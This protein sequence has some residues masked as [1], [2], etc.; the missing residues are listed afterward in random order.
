MKVF[1][2]LLLAV[3]LCTDPGKI[4]LHLLQQIINWKKRHV[5]GFDTEG[6]NTGPVVIRCLLFD[7]VSHVLQGKTQFLPGTGVILVWIDQLLGKI[8]LKKFGI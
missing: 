1:F 3:V 7:G 2:V 5:M 4:D 6:E 8:H